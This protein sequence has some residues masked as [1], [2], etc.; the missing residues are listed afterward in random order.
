MVRL[1]TVSY[2]DLGWRVH[3]STA[4]SD[5]A[6]KHFLRRAIHEDL[7]AHHPRIVLPRYCSRKR[8]ALS[9]T[10]ESNNA[11]DQLRV[12][13]RSCSPLSRLTLGVRLNGDGISGYLGWKQGKGALRL[14]I[15][16]REVSRGRG[17]IARRLRA[18]EFCWGRST[19]PAPHPSATTIR[20]SGGGWSLSARSHAVGKK[21]GGH[22][23][24][25]DQA[26][27]PVGVDERL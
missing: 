19:V 14:G 16:V 25:T 17:T 5:P 11:A 15:Y 23:C 3:L 18:A 6:V 22:A 9:T 13:R 2:Q 8:C 20:A 24:W 7:S 26:S 27:P 1:F 21:E 4:S 12:R 10:G